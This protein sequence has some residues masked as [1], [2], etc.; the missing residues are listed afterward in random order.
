[1]GPPRKVFSVA[2]KKNKRKKEKKKDPIGLA[3]SED[4]LNKVVKIM[5]KTHSESQNFWRQRSVRTTEVSMKLN[6][7][8]LSDP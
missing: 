8:S 7:P 4:M 6:Y 5:S 2:Q 1:M 3:I